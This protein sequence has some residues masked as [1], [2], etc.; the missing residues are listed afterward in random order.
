MKRKQT[1]FQT[2][3]ISFILV[4]L[5]ILLTATVAMPAGVTL[6]WDANDPAPEEYRVFSRKNGQAYD[7]S[8]H[9]WEGSGVTCTIDNLDGQT[10]YYF[11]VRACDGGMESADSNEVRYVPPTAPTD[12]S[13]TTPPSWNGATAG[14]GMAADNGRGGSV[15]VE[16]DTARDAVDGT[17]LRFNVYYAATGEWNN[18]SWT[19]NS[20]VADAAVGAGSTFAHAVTIGGLTDDV[21]YTFG[22]RA[23]DRSGNEDANK[24]T[25]TARVKAPPVGSIYD[26]MV[27]DSPD[28]SDAVFLEDTAVEGNI[29]VF[30]EPVKDI[31]KV[32]FFIDGELHQTE[33]YA[34]YDLAGSAGSG[35]AAPFDAEA[36]KSGAHTFSA[37]ITMTDGSRETIGAE[38]SANETDTGNEPPVFNPIAPADSMYEQRVSTAPDRSSPD[39]LD[40]ATVAGNIYVFVEPVTG[41]QKV[42]FY[43]DGV[44]HQTENRV[45]Y[46]LAGSVGTSRAY[47]F[48]TRVL[49]DG[50]HT[51][52]ARIT[53][54]DGGRETITSDVSVKNFSH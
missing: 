2:I 35:L 43:I 19:R 28:R 23:E 31:K 22:V 30:V 11:V 49:R 3:R 44:L 14:I 36:L 41:I 20:V 50:A 16:F 40:G 17:K 7:Y 52:S 8:R 12:T 9:A 27:S 5:L 32:E 26:L 29:Y 45:P 1:L 53:K 15:T 38:V 18:Y 47:P 34:P 51:F 37:R 42:E 39:E 54:T 46:D 48:D 6:R 13:D 25:L 33:N 10:E 4:P 24:N 21:R